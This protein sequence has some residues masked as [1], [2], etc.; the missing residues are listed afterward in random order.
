[1]VAENVEPLAATVKAVR[2]DLPSTSIDVD[3]DLGDGRRLRG[4]VPDVFGHRRIGATYS[5]LNPRHYLDAWLPA[6]A[7]GA[8]DPGGDWSS[9]MVTRPSQGD[10]AVT[11]VFGRVDDPMPILR[12]LVAMYDAGR[13]GPLPLPLKTGHAW[14]SKERDSTARFAA[15]KA[16]TTTDVFWP[17]EDADPFHVRVWG[18]KA[19]FEL[20]LEAPPGPDEAFAD[21]T[22]RLGALARRLWQPMLDRAV[23]S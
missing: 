17:K 22:T 16:W 19:P 18:E 8:N 15:R 13:R 6:L 21:E 11:L 14:A 23:I 12:D 4:T 3:I 20:L 9:G 2:G 5:R 7:L 1:V 10:E